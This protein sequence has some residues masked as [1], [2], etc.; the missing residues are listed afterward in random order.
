MKAKIVILLLL[1][2]MTAVLLS[3]SGAWGDVAR[4]TANSSIE[5]INSGADTI[6]WSHTCS[7]SDLFLVVNTASPRGDQP[8]DS[9]FY[10]GVRMDT[11]RAASAAFCEGICW[12]LVDPATGVNDVEVY[13]GGVSGGI[14][15]TCI[16]VSYTGVDQT[17]P[18]SAATD[19]TSNSASALEK[20]WAGG[21]AGEWIHIFLGKQYGG[22]W[23]TEGSGQTVNATE[24]GTDGSAT[25]AGASSYKT[26]EDGNDVVSYTSEA[27]ADCV[28]LAFVLEATATTDTCCAVYTSP[29]AFGEVDT[30][31]TKVDSFYIKNCGDSAFTDSID[32]GLNPVYVAQSDSAYSLSTGDSAWFTLQ[33]APTA[34]TSYPGAQ[35][36]GEAKCADL[37]IS[38]AGLEQIDTCCAV[39]TSPLAFGDVVL[40][41]AKVD[42]FYIQNCGDSA[43]VDSIDWANAPV[44]VPLSDSLYNLATDETKWFLVQFTPT[45]EQAYPESQDLGHDSCG[46]LTISGTGIAL[47][48]GETNVFYMSPTGNNSTGDGS[49]NNPY[50]TLSWIADNVLT[51]NTGDTVMV[52]SGTHA[53][54]ASAIGYSCLVRGHPDTF[55]TIMAD[56]LGGTK[57]VI[58]GNDI[59]ETCWTFYREYHWPAPDLPQYDVAYVRVKGITFTNPIG[60]N[61]NIT[62][63]GM[64]SRTYPAHHIIF[65]D[66][67]FSDPGPTSQCLKMAGVDTFL[68]KNCTFS[69]FEWASL[70]LVGC[71]RGTV[72][73]CYFSNGPSA[74]GDGEAIHIKGGSKDVTVDRCYFNEV[75]YSAV[76]IGGLT[77]INYFRPPF[78]T[79]DG[80]GI[81]CDYEAKNINVYRS[82][83]RE[84]GQ[85]ICFA[86]SRGGGVYNCAFYCPTAYGDPFGVTYMFRLY[87]FHTSLDGDTLVWPRD[88]EVI[89]N[90][91]VHNG[92]FSSYN[93][94]VFTQ[95]STTNPETFL[96]SHNLWHNLDDPGTV[97]GWD[98]LDGLY[99][100]PQHDN[101]ITGDPLFT[102][103]T[104]DT[105]FDFMLQTGSPAVAAGSTYVNIVYDWWNDEYIDGNDWD[106]TAWDNPRTLGVYASASDTC[107][108]VTGIAFSNTYVDSTATDS[109]YIYACGDSALTD[110]IDWTCASQYVLASD[111]I[112]DISS[113]DTAWFTV[114]FTPT[115]AV[116]YPDTQVAGHAVCSDI[117]FS[118]LGLVNTCCQVTDPALFG[119]VTVDATATDSFYIY[120]CGNVALV[121]SIDW[122]NM[123]SV[124]TLASD[125]IYNIAAGDTQWFTVEFTPTAEVS[126]Q[127]TIDTG[128]PD[129]YNTILYG[130]G[131]TP[132]TPDTI[133]ATS[134]YRRRRH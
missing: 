87:S 57:P 86:S 100:S 77:G 51:P 121:D 134:G 40:D 49:R 76:I 14:S 98:Y 110:S 69:G 29:L 91:V 55:L 124:Y 45:A 88:G 93:M 35:D 19:T 101:D 108:T 20:N 10:N 66:C 53:G 26:A 72:V 105:T 128:H 70:D 60:H 36:V 52:M 131:N 7:G 78:Y 107:C 109:F 2:F 25:S 59:T 127:D 6:I 83:F 54:D 118:G 67:D 24:I 1:L 94:V 92:S 3:S 5:P 50:Q 95:S 79:N 18:Y 41:D 84:T 116:S 119:Q 33:F 4:D 58:D 117:I 32:W 17:T 111:S 104:P 38:G 16:S 120:N 64:Y 15:I 62:D 39:Y 82:I 97:P 22:L 68:I 133:E 81:L 99:G 37:I 42:S 47:P 13:L 27:G 23:I 44:Y 71:H 122:V 114:E 34:V 73:G 90:I 132:D 80:D 61:V 8:I 103:A 106:D 28:L 30:G 56:P 123:L 112:Y 96:F 113:G 130:V 115:A 65:E 31:Q 85:P 89:N 75:G 11:I 46:T 12:G 102:D 43:L 129:C 126:Y 74:G 21:D 125:S 63:G 48:T 9:V